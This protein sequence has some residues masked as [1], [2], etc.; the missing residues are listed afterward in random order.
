MT[1]IISLKSG[2]NLTR[3]FVSD[4]FV[5][6]DVENEESLPPSSKRLLLHIE[7]SPSVTVGSN[8]F[9]PMEQIEE[10]SVVNYCHGL[11]STDGSQAVYHGHEV[12]VA[13]QD[14]NPEVDEEVAKLEKALGINLKNGVGGGGSGPADDLPSPA[15]VTKALL[16]K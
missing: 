7:E 9:N 2:H 8:P 11:G 4:V 10:L 3:A 15:A 12:V 16:A 1:K 6:T 5:T 13:A 14:E